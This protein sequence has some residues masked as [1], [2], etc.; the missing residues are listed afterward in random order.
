[1]SKK[2]L[3]SELALTVAL[4]GWGRENEFEADEWG[5]IY[6]A[7]ADHDPNAVVILLRRLQAMESGQEADLLSSLLATHPPTQERITRVEQVIREKGL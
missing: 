3:A 5:T 7:R 4:N 1:M 6:S 2:K